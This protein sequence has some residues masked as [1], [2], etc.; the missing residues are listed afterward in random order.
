[1]EVKDGTKV[2]EVIRGA[3]RKMVKVIGVEE[4]INMTFGRI[5]P[6]KTLHFEFLCLRFFR[7]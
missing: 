1:M 5:G 2:L 6:F 7:T 3:D 4:A